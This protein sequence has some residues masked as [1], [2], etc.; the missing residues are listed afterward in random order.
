MRARFPQSSF[1]QDR[2]LTET[3]GEIAAMSHARPAMHSDSIL[4]IA[5][6]RP[7]IRLEFQPMAAIPENAC[8]RAR[9]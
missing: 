6:V 8:R 4:E 5:V 7:V 1:S 3:R 9:T 2:R